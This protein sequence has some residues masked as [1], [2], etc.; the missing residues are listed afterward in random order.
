MQELGSIV[1]EIGKEAGWKV[2]EQERGVI[3]AD[4]KENRKEEG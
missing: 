4:E 1:E 3:D 2:S